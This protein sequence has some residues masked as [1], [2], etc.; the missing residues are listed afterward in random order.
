MND[1]GEA[2]IELT[3]SKLTSERIDHFGLSTGKTFASQV[4]VN[5]NLKQL[6]VY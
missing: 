4:S 3:L 1:F 6:T 2:R 5:E